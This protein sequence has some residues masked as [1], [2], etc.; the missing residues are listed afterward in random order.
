M[1]FT[2][3]RHPYR[4]V[5]V[6]ADRP[7][8]GDVDSGVQVGVVAVAAGLTPERLI[9]AVPEAVTGDPVRPGLRQRPAHPEPY[10]ADL[11]N[12]HPRPRAADLLNPAGL[13]TDDTEPFTPSGF[14]PGGAVMAA[15]EEVPAGLVEVPQRLLLDG[16]RPITQPAEHGTRLGQLPRLLNESRRRAFVA[17]P[18]RPLLNG[19][20]PHISR[21]PTLSQQPSS[22]RRRGTQAVARH[23]PDPTSHRRHFSEHT[24][25]RESRLHPA[26]NDGASPRPI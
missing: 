3:H 5:S 21:L 20:V 8:G 26:I 22:L 6:R 19:Q 10:P 2:L 1:R 7:S 14:A 18:H 25:R 17:C 11:R 23:A 15:G 16:L 24:E 13:R 4:L 12:Q 9:L